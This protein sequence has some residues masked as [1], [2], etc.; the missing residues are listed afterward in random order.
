LVKGKIGEVTE[1]LKQSLLELALD[2][3]KSTSEILVNQRPKNMEFESKSTPVDLVT[4]MDKAAE[5]H[6]VQRVKE[7]RPNDSFLGEEGTAL[8]PENPSNVKWIIDPIDGTV[9]YFYNHPYWAISIG[10]EI[11]GEIQVGVVAAPL[12]HETFYAIKG[13]GSYVIHDGVKNK[14]QAN[15]EATI[16]KALIATGFGYDP[17]RRK[18]QGALLAELVAIVRDVRRAGAAS[19]DF[20][21]VAAGRIDAYYEFGLYPWDYAAG[22]LILTEA[23]GKVGGLSGNKLGGDWS[24]GANA[25]LFSEIDE[26]ITK[27]SKKYF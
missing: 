2:I 14:L 20:C 25:D 3:A 26:L 12:L 17:E 23:G 7:V 1:S 15:T 19:L 21:Y 24:L 11:D 6:I 27:L 9:N 13:G 18:K 8:P 22:A 16:D 10:V 4:E 5:R